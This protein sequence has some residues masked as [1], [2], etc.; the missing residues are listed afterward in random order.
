MVA[1]RVKPLNESGDGRELFALLRA[2][3]T[4][5]VAGESSSV[6]VKQLFTIVSVNAG[7]GESGAKRRT[8]IEPQ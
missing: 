8:R 1:F 2:V 5:E 3:Q 6:N 7:L 4:K